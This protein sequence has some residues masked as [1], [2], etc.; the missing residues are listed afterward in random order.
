MTD[1]ELEILRSAIFCHVQGKPGES[2]TV[3]SLA[4]RGLLRIAMTHPEWR[5][6]LTHLGHDALTEEVISAKFAAFNQVGTTEEKIEELAK[7]LREHMWN[8][9][10]GPR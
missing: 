4:K 2:K 6:G 7:I 1:E 5:W 8:K 9:A 10:R 3:D